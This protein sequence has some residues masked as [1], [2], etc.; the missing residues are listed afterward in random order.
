[1]RHVCARVL[2]TTLLFA[3]LS[4]M[5]LAGGDE[6]ASG[7]RDAGSGAILVDVRAR[8]EFVAQAGKQDAELTSIRS[9]LGWES[10]QWG[11]FTFLGEIENTVFIQDG[12]FYN[13]L[14]GQSQHAK[15]GNAEFTELQRLQL[16]YEINESVSV[17][18]GRQ[19]L[20]FDDGRFVGSPGSS[21]DKNSHDAL[22]FSFAGPG[23]H[24][25]YVYHDQ[26]NR[27]PGDRNEWEG[28]SHLFHARYDFGEHMNVSGFAYFIDL[29]GSA[30]TRSNVTYGGWVRG[31]YDFADAR[32]RYAA[33][34]AQQSE[35]GDNPAHFDLSYIVTDA[36]LYYGSFKLAAGWDRLEGDGSNRILNPLGANHSVLGYADVFTGGGRQGTVDGLEDANLAVY[37]FV[38]PEHG[39]F[40]QVEF[41]L[42]RHEFSAQRTG[43][44]LGSEWDAWVSFDLPSDMT[45]RFDYSDFEGSSDPVS[46]GDK[47]KL[48]IALTYRR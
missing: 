34:I 16:T 13:G 25:D 30:A 23:F 26:V 9:L 4:G 7:E 21:Q 41:G 35:Y 2:S 27:G 22:R 32:F 45:L 20:G 3:T 18:A 47:T 40:E 38:E 12:G 43:S 29:Q 42:R 48:W 28:E 37:Y 10:P 1:M 15:I 44:D 17:T 33:M 6:P 8:A 14:N 5:A 39:F 31:G 24:A 11:G 19:Y 36:S 46:P